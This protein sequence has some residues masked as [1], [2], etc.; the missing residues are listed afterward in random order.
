MRSKPILI[1][2]A[3]AAVA[4]LV[5][6]AAGAAAQ[7]APRCGGPG[8][9]RCDPGFFCQMAAGVCPRQDARGVCARKPR[10]CDF[11]EQPVCGCNGR[12]YTNACT[13]SENGVNIAHDGA[14]NAIVRPLPG[15]PIHGR[16]A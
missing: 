11:I 12:T 5:L 9:I 3:L 15:V 14:C 2:F 6:F 10:F 7:A 13:A 1:R 8:H 4:G 16:P